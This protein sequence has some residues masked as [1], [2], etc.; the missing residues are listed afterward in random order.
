MPS[1]KV[2][3]G[4]RK[5]LPR[6]R[7]TGLIPAFVDEAAAPLPSH[8]VV[9]PSVIVPSAVVPSV[10]VP[11]VVVPS[12]VVPSAPSAHHPAPPSTTR[13]GLI[14]QIIQE[15]KDKRAQRPPAPLLRPGLIA[16]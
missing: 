4:R 11:S 10:I 1:A 3:A 9:R 5:A 6:S 13:Q 12:V 14:S 2:P 15:A 8:S 7:L 16:Q